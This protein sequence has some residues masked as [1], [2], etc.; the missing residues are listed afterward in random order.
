MRPKVGELFY[1]VCFD[2]EILRLNL[3]R[4]KGGF[5]DMKMV[6]FGNY[7]KTHQQAKAASKIIKGVFRQIK[8]DW[9]NFPEFKRVKGMK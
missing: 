7:F 3:M 9:Q 6:R 2:G 8:N 1:A 5:T 4:E